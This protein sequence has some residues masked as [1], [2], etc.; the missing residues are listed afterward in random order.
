M[1]LAANNDYDDTEELF[2]GVKTELNDIWLGIQ[3]SQ[4]CETIIAADAAA[5]AASST[6]SRQL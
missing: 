5:A 3:M 4:E 1:Q 6:H 2:E